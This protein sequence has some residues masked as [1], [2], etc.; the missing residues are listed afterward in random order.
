MFDR[1]C[2]DDNGCN[3]TGPFHMY[4]SRRCEFKCNLWPNDGCG[5]LIPFESTAEHAKILCMKRRTRCNYSN[6]IVIFDQKDTHM[7][8]CQMY[9]LICKCQ[10]R[11]FPY[12]LKDHEV[13]DCAFTDIGCPLFKVNCCDSKCTGKMLRFEK[14]T[15]LLKQ[16]EN[17]VAMEKLLAKITTLNK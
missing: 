14:R 6:E 8:N 11:L 5:E 3:W 4:E 9:P 7:N 15:H 17:L 12:E 13:N 2:L 16:C 10:E 1:C